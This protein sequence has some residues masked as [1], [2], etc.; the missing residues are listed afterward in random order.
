MYFKEKEDT[1][2]DNELKKSK[3]VD[4]KK[5]SKVFF[6]IIGILVALIIIGL[7]IVLLIKK[8]NR[9]FLILNGDMNMTIYKGTIYN[10]PG[11]EAYDN[12]KNSLNDQVIVNS[13]LDPNTIGTYKI[14]YTLNNK[15][16]TRTIKVVEKPDIITIIHLNGKYNIYLNVGDTYE[17]PG[18]SAI[19]AVE[20]DLTN[21]VK[22]NSNLD[23]S[24]Q[25]TYRIIYSV[26][27]S[28]GVTTS[29]TRTIIVQ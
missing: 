1:N 27:N 13:N 14:V 5:I 22:I 17:E 7:L 19:D 9:E 3:K 28:D 8:M 11:Y 2:I 29:E 21:K 16:K 24:K 23:T 20:G 12:N 6:T 26:T 4:K 25:G 15:S 10:E 18:Y